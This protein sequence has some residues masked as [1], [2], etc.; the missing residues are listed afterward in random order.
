MVAVTEGARSAR[1]RFMLSEATGEVHW[2]AVVAGVVIALATQILLMLLGLAVGAATLDADTSA[3]AARNGWVAY[4]W[5]AIAGIAGSF[6]GGWAAGNISSAVD[7]DRFEGAFQGFMSWALT[8]VLVATFLSSSAGG[9]PYIVRLA[10]PLAM[11]V[12]TQHAVA[13]G[14]L[15]AFIALL[16]G[17]AAALIAGYL[18][19]GFVR[20]L[21]AG[22]TRVITS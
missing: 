13:V 5:W 12:P 22:P 10:G 16:S 1:A 19:S 20:R 21:S 14:A 3:E 6:A 15:W 9:A 18:G 2:N 17:A 7:H 11:Q 4:A 8:V